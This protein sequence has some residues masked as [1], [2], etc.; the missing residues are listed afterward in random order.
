MAKYLKTFYFLIKVTTIASI[1]MSLQV[2][3][4]AASERYFCRDEST[5]VTFARSSKGKEIRLILW[6]SKYFSESPKQRCDNTSRKLQTYYENRWLK[7]IKAEV[8]NNLG[9]ICVAREKSGNCAETDIIVVLPPKV[10]P[11]DA[12]NNLLDMRRIVH[13]RPLYLT[14]HLVTYKKGKAYVNIDMFLSRLD[15]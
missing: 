6:L 15:N 8:V 7:Y 12:L 9:V 13:G 3:T 1:V 2:P 11:I 10:N 4:V 5:P 14:D